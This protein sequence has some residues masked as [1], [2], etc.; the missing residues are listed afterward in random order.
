MWREGGGGIGGGKGRGGKGERVC[1]NFAHK[2]LKIT[3]ID[4]SMGKIDKEIKQ[5]NAPKVGFE[6]K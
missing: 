3:T 2:M 5:N 6:E 1:N 4:K